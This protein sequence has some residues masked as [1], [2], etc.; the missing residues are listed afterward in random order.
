MGYSTALYAVDLDVLTATVGSG[1]AKLLARLRPASKAKKLKHPR[2]F[3]NR[4]GEIFLNGQPFAFNDLLTELRRRKWRGTE[5]HYNEE[6][7]IRAGKWTKP[8]SLFHAIVNAMSHTQFEGY[9][10]GFDEDDEDDEEDEFTVEEAAAELVEGRVSRRNEGHQYGYGLER[11]CKLIGSRLTTIEGKGGM[12]KALQL[13]TALSK[14]RP[15]VKLSKSR[16]DFPGVGHLTADEVA[17]E[18]GRFAAADLSFPADDLIEADRA[19]FLKALQ[20]AAK[21]GVGVVAFYY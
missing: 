14:E 8:Y 12:L 11:L 19:E 20:K 6:G 18:V 3:Q 1:D 7:R 5:L 13:K 10:L 9:N 17:S 2:V 16:N 4:K 21:K 15:P